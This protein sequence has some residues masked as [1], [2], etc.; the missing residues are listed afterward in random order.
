MS[1]ALATAYACGWSLATT[2][3]TCVVVFRAGDDDFGVYLNS[4]AVSQRSCL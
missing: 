3:M 1:Q 2:L 4:Q